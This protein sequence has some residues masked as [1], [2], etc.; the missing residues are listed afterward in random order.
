M[1]LQRPLQALAVSTLVVGLTVA[2]LLA[3]ETG[4]SEKLGLST[5]ADREGPVTVVVDSYAASLR[6]SDPFI[7]I[8]IALGIVAKSKTVRFGLESFTLMDRKGNEV[9]LASY[10]DVQNGYDKRLADDAVLAQRPMMLDSRFDALDRVDSHF[11]PSPAGRG[12]RATRVELA[13]GTWLQDVLYFP[14]PP[15]GTRGVLTLKIRG[16]GLDHTIAV[17]FRVHEPGEGEQL[18][19]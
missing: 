5:Y 12:T 18:Q 15:A 3:V 10:L 13:P 4:V 16:K 8:R 19:D 9:P 14:R 1:R 17:R 6:E 11:F 2:P 7:P